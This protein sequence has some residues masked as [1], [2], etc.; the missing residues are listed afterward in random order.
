MQVT[1]Y[2]R[3]GKE[4]IRK[5]I[6]DFYAEIKNDEVLSPMY[7]GDFEEAEERLYLFMVQ[8][9]GGPD[10]YNRQ[11]GHPRLKMRHAD[12]LIDEKAKM[13]WLAN[14]K[15]ALDRSDI[16]EEEKDFLW[17]YFQQTASFLKN[18]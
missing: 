4:K 14:M 9:L 15:N 11:R 12:F 18:H 13:H 10:L 6:R 16:G 3:I 7:K 2:D 5:L 8:Y 1:W 17:S